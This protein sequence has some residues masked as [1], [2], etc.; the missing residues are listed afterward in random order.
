M[1]YHQYT[2]QYITYN[3]TMQYNEN[4]TFNAMQYT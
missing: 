4:Y 3:D 1:S 2:L